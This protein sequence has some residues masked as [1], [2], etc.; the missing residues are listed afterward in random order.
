MAKRGRRS[1]YS[2]WTILLAGGVLAYAILGSGGS[3]DTALTRTPAPTRTTIPASAPTIARLPSIT[4][5]P[6]RAVT[7][8]PR[9]TNPP[10]QTLY[11]QD[12]TYYVTGDS[13]NVRLESSTA[14]GVLFVARRGTTL[15]ITGEQRG[16]RVSGSDLWYMVAQGEAVGYIHSSLISDTRPAT[17]AP[18]P[19][20]PPAQQAQPV[21]TQPPAPVSQPNDAQICGGATRC[22]QMASCEQAYACLRAGRG[23]LDRDNDGVPCESICPG[24]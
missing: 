16:M 17:A 15:A 8:T 4:F 5:T 7:D 18:R 9:P 3:R 13:V 21:S 23:S 2:T 10:G 1:K 22:D 19:T 20:N 6:S 14:S 11:S 12:R 24:G